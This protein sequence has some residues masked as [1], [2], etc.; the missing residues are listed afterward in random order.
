VEFK[1][2]QEISEAISKIGSSDVI[3]EF[4]ERVADLLKVNEYGTG[5]QTIYI[6]IICVAPEFD[7]FFKIRKPKYYKDKTII[8]DGR[9]YR[10]I[11][12]FTY[13]IKLNYEQVI[14]AS[15]HEL[16]KMLSDEVIKSLPNFEKINNF[17]IVKFKSELTEFLRHS[18][19]N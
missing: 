9:P 1:I 2:T 19:I 7:S 4:S 3:E 15:K 18:S 17:N 13:D 12:T 16:L 8:Q 6:G 10:L 5:L 11:N 14:L